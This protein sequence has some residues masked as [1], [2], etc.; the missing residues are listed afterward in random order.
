MNK[1]K[2]GR[3]EFLWLTLPNCF[4]SLEKIR[5]GTQTGKE[6]GDRR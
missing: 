5:I 4:S 3:K 1:A 2:L 6:P